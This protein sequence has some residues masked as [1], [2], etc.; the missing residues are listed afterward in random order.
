[1]R[2]P[3]P[4]ALAIPARKRL[5][6][7]FLKPLYATHIKPNQEV[8]MNTTNPFLRC[9][10]CGQPIQQKPRGRERRTCSH[11]CRQKLW[12]LRIKGRQAFNDYKRRN[13]TIATPMRVVGKH[14]LERPQ[15]ALFH[16]CWFCDDSVTGD[17]AFAG[18]DLMGEVRTA[19]RRCKGHLD[20]VIPVN[21]PKALR[22]ER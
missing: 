22:S 15:Y 9:A 20:A 12:R 19:C 5:R 18:L 1:M 11:A 16:T 10:V 4:P 14:K 21:D 3:G 6:P 7:G 2:R 17:E 13:P 8:L